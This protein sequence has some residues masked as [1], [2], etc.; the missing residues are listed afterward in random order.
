[1]EYIDLIITV[2]YIRPRLYEGKE[3][4]QVLAKSLADVSTSICLLKV[5]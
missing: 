5:I 4:L 1:M 2:P 3:I